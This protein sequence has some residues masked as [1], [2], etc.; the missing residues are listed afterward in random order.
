MAAMAT[1]GDAVGESFGVTRYG[2]VRQTHRQGQFPLVGSL[3]GHAHRCA[4]RG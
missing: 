2:K 3:S 1:I 4:D